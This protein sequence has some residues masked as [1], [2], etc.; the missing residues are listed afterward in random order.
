L[1]ALNIVYSS[2]LILQQAHPHAVDGEDV[3]QIWVCENTE[4]QSDHQQ[5]VTGWFGQGANNCKLYTINVLQDVTQHLRIARI[6]WNDPSNLQNYNG[7]A[8]NL[9]QNKD[10]QWSVVGKETSRSIKCLVEGSGGGYRLFS[11]TLLHGSTLRLL[12]LCTYRMHSSLKHEYYSPNILLH[13]PG[14]E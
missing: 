2:H 4:Q 9:A 13:K 5:V 11:G 7:T 10:K 6:L 1:D 12:V 8:S 3:L 14:T